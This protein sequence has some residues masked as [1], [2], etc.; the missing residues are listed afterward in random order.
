MARTAVARLTAE[1]NKV[2]GWFIFRYTAAMAGLFAALLTPVIIGLSLKLLA[3][4]SA[5]ATTNLALV[6]GVGAFLAMAANPF[7]G[8]LSDRTVG[9]FG[10]R[11]PWLLAGSV[12]GLGGLAIIAVGNDIPTILV[13]WCIAQIAF[14]GTLATLSAVIA[15]QVPKKQRGTVSGFLG[16]A[17]GVGIL[18]GVALAQ[19]FTGNMF[20]LFIVPGIV[21]LVLIFLFALTFKDR[22]LT[23]H[24][25]E[26]YDFRLFI[27]SFWTNPFKYP[28][29]GWAWLSRFSILLALSFVTTY[30]TFYLLK[31][32][33]VPQENVATYIFLGSLS[34]IG[35]LVLGSILGG[36]L[37]DKFH[38]RKLFV[39]VS[40][41]ICVV[42][43]A[44]LATGNSVGIFLL[45][46]A[47]VGL[48]QGAYMAVDL[49]LVTEVLPNKKDTAK[50]LGV[51]NIAN[52][53]PQSVAPAI[54]PI[55]LAINGPDNF[56]SLFLA[57]AVFAGIAAVAV[58]PIRK[59]K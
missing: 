7:F 33:G 8:R 17:Q 29:F 46:A 42:A 47:I 19:L 25:K 51:I 50:D 39:W 14:N 9:R 38:R 5:N 48:A 30:Q 35:V 15:D 23:K 18:I 57:A 58:F 13:G 20:L 32:V 55:F 6:A 53:L 40:A 52:A 3:L 56:T 10:M 34:S 54:A 59:V 27:K 26:P 44:L 24:S 2:S 1:P 22:V 31:Q 21:G 11:R 49:A 16:I 36:F 41:A 45:A 4:D 43:L 28:S 12:V 37:S